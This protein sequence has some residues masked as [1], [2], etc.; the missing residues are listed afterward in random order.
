MCVRAIVH[1]VIGRW[2]VDGLHVL[3]HRTTAVQQLSE[4]PS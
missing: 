3:Y 2:V 1:V 4:E